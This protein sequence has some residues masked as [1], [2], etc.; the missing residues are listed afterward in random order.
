MYFKEFRMLVVINYYSL[1]D[2]IQEQ[3]LSQCA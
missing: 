1:K 2:V 3:K